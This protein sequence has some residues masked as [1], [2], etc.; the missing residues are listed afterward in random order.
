VSITQTPLVSVIIPAFNA[1]QTVA[2]TLESL[3]AQTYERFE[4]IIVEDGSTD[5]TAA[6][7]RK[8][9]AVDPRFIFATKP[10]SGLPGTRN[11]GIEIARGEFLAFL[12]ADDVWLP[13]K[14]ARQMDLFRVD[15]RVNL[16]FTNF[17]IWDGERDLL[18]YYRENRPLPDGD[19]SRQLLFS[20]VFGI[21]SVI[22]RRAVFGGEGLFDASLIGGSEDWDLWLRLAERGLFV[23]GTREPLM[24]YRRWPGNMSNRKLKMAESELRVVEKNLRASQ[25]P[26][27]R[28]LYRRSLNRVRGRLELVRARQLIDAAPEKVPAAIWHAWRLNQREGKWLLWL[29]LAA[30]PKFLGGRAT[31]KIVHRKLIEKF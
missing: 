12:D 10:H 14:L 4:A 25:R 17:F 2:Q 16:A 13:E 28:S 1:A 15:S 6:I 29:A 26:E 18:V 3:R 5:D 9:C 8:F 30:W 24:R 20:S 23:R 19:I 21:S 27:L 7:V 22:L 31:E 11:A